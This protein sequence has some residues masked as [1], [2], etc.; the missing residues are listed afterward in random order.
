MQHYILRCKHCNR[1][2]VYCTYGNG[3]EYGTE[4]GCSQ[5]YCAECQK[6]ID[7]ALGKIPVKFIKK[8]KQIKPTKELL[9]LF[10]KVKEDTK[11]KNPLQFPTVVPLMMS[12]YDNFATCVYN[13]NRF[14]IEWNDDD[15]D[16][17]IVHVEYEWDCEK[18]EFTDKVWKCREKNSYVHTRPPKFNFKPVDF[19]KIK[20][21][22]LPT[23]DLFYLSIPETAKNEFK[24]QEPKEPQIHVYTR[25][26]YGTV[27]L[28]F[29]KD[30]K[31]EFQCEVNSDEVYPFLEY[32][33]TTEETDG[34]PNVIVKSV[35]LA[36]IKQ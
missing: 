2:Y 26:Y 13:G 35:N 27:L 21:M 4:E 16:N 9:A 8:P 1:E 10:D 30:D 7:E 11:S 29:L 36:Y 22:D 31:Y 33:I 15:I 23:G 25:K 5:E 32:H 14:I 3:P 20:P 12:P 24:K 18:K 28:N 6:A 17:K 19:T 34:K